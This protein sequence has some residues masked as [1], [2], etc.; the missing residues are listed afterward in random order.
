[1][2]VYAWYCIGFKPTISIVSVVHESLGH[3][4]SH[5]THVRS[6]Q[7][8]LVF[9]L[10][11]ATRYETRNVVNHWLKSV[12]SPSTCHIIDYSD[13]VEVPLARRLSER[14]TMKLLVAL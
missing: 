10:D 4:D 7:P 9:G 6:F 11:R 1:M 5:C 13:A 3:Y 8:K 2:C 14:W 12:C